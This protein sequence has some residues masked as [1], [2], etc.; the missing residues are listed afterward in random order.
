MARM[1]ARRKGRSGSKRPLVTKSPDWVPLEGDEI[2]ETVA[3]L[4]AQGKRSAE[5]GGVLRDQY[6]V[7]NVRL[8]TG[9]TVT[10][11]MRARGTKFSMPEDLADLMRKAV[12]LQSH[13][14]LNLKDLSNLRGLQLIESKIR[15]LARYYQEEGVLP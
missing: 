7:P 4:A 2:E 9:K 14:K 13:L 10:E 11:I 6:A 5:I 1:H 12:D 8:A 3:R 15:R